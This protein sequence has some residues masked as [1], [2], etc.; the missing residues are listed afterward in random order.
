[1]LLLRTRILSW[2]FH[3]LT[4]SIIGLSVS[5]PKYSGLAAALG[6]GSAVIH[7][8]HI[9]GQ[10]RGTSAT[11]FGRRPTEAEIGQWLEDRY[12]LPAGGLFRGD[13]ERGKTQKNKAS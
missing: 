3:A 2:A 9:F 4:A 8:T 12:Q 5:D 7:S 13:L 10:S 11:P 1:M 6:I